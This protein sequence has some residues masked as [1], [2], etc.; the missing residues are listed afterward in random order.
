VDT[1][2][3]RATLRGHLRD[4]LSV[5]YCP[6]GKTLASGGLDGAILLW[7]VTPEK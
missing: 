6:D 4:V 5:A 2:K 1:G 3:E 7:D